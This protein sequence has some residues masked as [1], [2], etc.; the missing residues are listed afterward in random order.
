MVGC[1][2]FGVRFYVVYRAHLCCLACALNVAGV[3]AVICVRDEVVSQNGF[4]HHQLRM[5][6]GK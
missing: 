1:A 5:R 6:G 2:L 4:H 3:A